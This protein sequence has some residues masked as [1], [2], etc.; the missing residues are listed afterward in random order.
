MVLRSLLFLSLLF[1][2]PVYACLV[3]SVQD[4]DTLTLFCD[5]E[6]RV[7]DLDEIDAPE[8]QQDFGKRSQR[9]LSDMCLR[10][11]A[12]L[13]DERTDEDGRT[14]A[15]VLCDGVPAGAEQLRRGMAWVSETHAEDKT[16][17]VAQNIARHA[18]HGLWAGEAPVAP[19][20]WRRVAA[21]QAEAAAKQTAVRRTPPP[22]PP[23][24]E[25]DNA[26]VSFFK[27]LFG[28]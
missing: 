15:R 21:A 7:I 1:A 6:T 28:Q 4:G 25:T 16:L 23:P 5:G 24:K 3:V 17:H 2:G 26:V 20:E 18:G 19:W 22:S 13:L 27:R 12:R 11:N 14:F 9:S 8:L 10:R